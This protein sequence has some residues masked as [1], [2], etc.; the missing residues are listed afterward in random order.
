LELCGSKGTNLSEHLKPRT[1]KKI[2]KSK[3]ALA[4]LSIQVIG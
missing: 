4:L 1:A 2:L 3:T